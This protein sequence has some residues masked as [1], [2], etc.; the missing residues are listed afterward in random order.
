MLV[1]ITNR[2]MAGAGL[3]EKVE[4]ALAG[5]VTHIIL[6]EKDMELEDLVLLAGEIR[7]ISRPWGA[8]LFINSVP[9][10]AISVAKRVGAD[11]IHLTYRHYLEVIEQLINKET[12][13]LGVSIHSIE[14]VQQIR[15]YQLKEHE[16]KESHSG[17]GESPS[18]PSYILAG[19][20]FETQCKV[21]LA[22]KGLEFLNQICQEAGSIP[23]VA[24]GGISKKNIGEVM[25]S[26]ASGAAVMG[27]FMTHENPR[28]LAR[29]LRFKQ[30]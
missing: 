9:D 5:G 13:G 8:K 22:G 14:E 27:A 10:I 15:T 3:I 23:V 2:S 6:R 24:I 12:L 7:R 18:L 17:W 4:E 30:L 26:G 19:N 1:L 28:E 20:I 11:G 21:G 16:P 29:E 25:A